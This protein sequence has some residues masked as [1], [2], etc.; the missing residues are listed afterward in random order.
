MALA[1]L[2]S[3]SFC[4]W[5]KQ[6]WFV[7]FLLLFFWDSTIKFITIISSFSPILGSKP[8][9]WPGVFLLH[10]GWAFLVCSYYTG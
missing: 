9:E 1:N 6:I 10:K 8:S 3:E 7:I 2:K 4:D 5:T